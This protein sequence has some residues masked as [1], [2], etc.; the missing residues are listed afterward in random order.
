M[1]L[2]RY[3]P[4]GQEKPGLLDRDGRAAYV[5]LGR[6][7]IERDFS[8]SA[9]WMAY[10]AMLMIIGFVRRSALVRWQALILIAAT[11]AKVFIYDVSQLDREY[12][13]VSFIIL[14]VLLLAISFVYQRDWLQLSAKT[15]PRNE[16]TVPG[17]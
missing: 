14:G 1:K 4:A 7:D 3:G 12:R 10:G 2:L 17:A 6:N 8:Y 11:I 5:E 15:Q 16:G 13:I 9:L